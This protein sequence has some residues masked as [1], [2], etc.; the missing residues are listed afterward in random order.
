MNLIEI[1]N[2]LDELYV[3]ELDKEK[4]KKDFGVEACVLSAPFLINVPETYEMANKKVLYI[5]KETNIWWGKLKHFIDYDDSI[6]ILKRRYTAEFEG[7]SLPRSRDSRVQS[8]PYIGEDWKNNAFFSKYKYFRSNIIGASVL[9][10]NLLKM[11]NGSKD[12]SKNSINNSDVRKYSKD[13]LLQEIAI[14]KPDVII[15]VTA[16]STNLK[17]YDDAIK[18]TFDNNFQSS[19]V[20]VPQQLWIFEYAGIKCYRTVHPLSHQFRKLERDYYKEIA[21]DI[22]DG[23]PLFKTCKE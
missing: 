17:K 3:K 18:N 5:G 22:N 1:Q 10:T 13:I 19:E 21:E 2:K 20:C 12:Y 6:D 8:A 14:L 23:F 11:D 16:T 9:W 4:L 15:F 7:G